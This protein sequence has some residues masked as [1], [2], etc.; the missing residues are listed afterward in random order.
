MYLFYINNQ[1]QLT[2]VNYGQD[3]DWLPVT[4]D[5]AAFPD[6]S[7]S[8][9]SFSAAAIAETEVDDGYPNFGI[10]L[11]L[12][13]DMEMAKM[14]Y[15]YERRVNLDGGFSIEI[16]WNEVTDNLFST[17]QA[18]PV[19]TTNCSWSNIAI[20]NTT[21]GTNYTVN[22]GCPTA[23]IDNGASQ[24]WYSAS[25]STLYQKNATSSE[26]CFFFFLSKVVRTIRRERERD[27]KEES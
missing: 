17:I 2:L 6:M 24:P 3:P 9:K 12:Y 25:F 11:T 7:N 10:L 18:K 16:I 13:D 27:K 26:F 22:L 5:L 23:I 21:Y 19:D 1:S 20:S 8:S 15:G 14:F 4:I